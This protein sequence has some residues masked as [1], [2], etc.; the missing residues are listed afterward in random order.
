MVEIKC[1]RCK[2]I[3]G[4]MK[5]ERPEHL[6]VMCP[7]CGSMQDVG[8]KRVGGAGRK[9]AEKKETDP[10]KLIPKKISRPR[11]RPRKKR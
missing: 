3:F 11:G 10:M 7:W 4:F 1:T 5:E 9:P 6:K 2:K 8:I